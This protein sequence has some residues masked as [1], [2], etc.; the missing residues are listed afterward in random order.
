M[1]LFGG[2]KK[3]CPICGSPA[4]RFLA[5]KLEG[6]PLCG[7][8][9]GKA[10][11]F[12]GGL[13]QDS[14]TIEQ[15]RG[16]VSFYDENAALRGAFT[17]SYR[18]DLGFFGGSISLD[19]PH[20]LLRL[21]PADKEVVFEAEH[22]RSFRILEDDAPL[23]EG[24]R[25]ALLCYQSTVPDQVR[26]LRPEIDR[27]LMEQ[28]QYEQLERID[29]LM[30]ER[31]KEAGEHYS[32]EYWPAPNVD[33]LKPFDGFNIWLELDH[34]Y[35]SRKGYAQSAP[36]FYTHDPS[37]TSYL[38]EY[39]ERTQA[40]HQLASQLMA[41][42]A[43]EAPER[44]ADRPAGGRAQPADAPAAPVD[45]VAEIQRYKGL[46]DSGII[47]EEEFAAKKRQLLGI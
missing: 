46:L 42:L 7:D 37:I 41:V 5:T 40:L 44:Q 24:T 34:P 38:N 43:P 47:T 35:C 30:E 6:Q 2:S 20:R 23:F 26:G 17:E 14:M 3:L 13:D 33:R 19:V 4:G 15:F 8:C 36:G 10:T 21:G 11:W 12:P 25:D 39:E 9:G 28:R 32:K 22:F 18:Y 45:A 1:G 27:F 31:A 16:F 29:K